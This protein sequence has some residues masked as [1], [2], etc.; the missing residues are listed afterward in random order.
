MAHNSLEYR[1]GIF[2]IFYD[3][4][5]VWNPGQGAVLRQSVGVGFRQRG[6]IVAIA[7]PL[8]EGRAEPMFMV[9]MNY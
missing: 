4:G 6:F 2:Q 3:T 9:G 5:A 7:F 8:R 1:Y